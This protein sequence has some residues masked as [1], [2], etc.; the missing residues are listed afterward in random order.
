[1]L[2]NS[3]CFSFPLDYFLLVWFIGRYKQLKQTNDGAMKHEFSM[4]YVTKQK[5]SGNQMEGARK[6][7]TVYYSIA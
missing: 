5:A 1:M 3:G 7:R 4:A 6:S 2:A